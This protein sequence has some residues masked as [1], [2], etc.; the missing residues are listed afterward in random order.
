MNWLLL[1]VNWRMKLGPETGG[2]LGRLSSA[3]VSG[4]SRR[5]WTTTRSDRAGGGGL[6]WGRIEAGKLIDEAGRSGLKR[7][8]LGLGRM[9]VGAEVGERDGRP[10]AGDMDWVG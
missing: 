8:K 4:T 7:C 3:R 5:S 1:M 6:G 10:S 2:F 9:G